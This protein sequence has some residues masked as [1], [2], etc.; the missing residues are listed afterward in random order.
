[1][2]KLLPKVEDSAS[3]E[4]VSFPISLW[5][6]VLNRARSGEWEPWP[7]VFGLIL[8]WLLFQSLNGNFL[9]PR[10]LSNLVLQSGVVG[11][12]GIGVVAW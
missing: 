2:R 12:L 6:K 7:V 1:M 8:T 4:V 3:H 5:D 10:N 9:T 11:T